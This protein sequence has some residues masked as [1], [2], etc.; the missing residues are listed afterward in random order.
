L[1]G[2]IYRPGKGR[3]VRNFIQGGAATLL[4]IPLE[5]EQQLES[6]QL[7]IIENDVIIDLTGITLK[8]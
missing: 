4:D 7:E 5:K 3:G 1:T 8:Q 2:K 6:L